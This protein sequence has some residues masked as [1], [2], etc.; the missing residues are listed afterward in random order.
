MNRENERTFLA[1]MKW[2]YKQQRVTLKCAQNCVEMHTVH[3][4]L[5]IAH[6]INGNTDKTTDDSVSK[7]TEQIHLINNF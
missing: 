1:H 3:C 2:N 4:T 7:N 6:E 5:H